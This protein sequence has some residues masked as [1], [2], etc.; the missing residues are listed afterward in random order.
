M[1]AGSN[2]RHLNG[3]SLGMMGDPVR[4]LPKVV[5][6]DV[7]ALKLQHNPH[8]RAIDGVEQIEGGGRIIT[9][10]PGQRVDKDHA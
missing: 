3:L 7:A 10:R 1:R 6:P 9:R 8:E 4:C 2:W 5:H